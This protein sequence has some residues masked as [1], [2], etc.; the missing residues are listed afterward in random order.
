VWFNAQGNCT[1]MF[2]M[3]SLLMGQWQFA[4]VD[5]AARVI[6]NELDQKNSYYREF[7]ET[8][9][10]KA[11]VE[12][13]QL[14]LQKIQK[15]ISETKYTLSRL[16]QAIQTLKINQ[17]NLMVRAVEIVQKVAEKRGWIIIWETQEKVTW[18]ESEV[19]ETTV[20][21]ENCISHHLQALEI[22]FNYLT[23]QLIH[24]EA[25]A[26]R[27]QSA[28]ETRRVIATE[29]LNRT[30]QFITVIMVVA[31]FAQ[32]AGVLSDNS[33]LFPM[34]LQQLDHQIFYFLKPLLSSSIV[35]LGLFIVFITVFVFKMFGRNS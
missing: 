13:L 20:I 18:F 27:W 30:G 23:G 29:K 22:S 8:V 7:D 10:L 31:A 9:L 6:M 17:N 19:T 12:N 11:T 25:S 26:L 33:T 35:Y 21:L 16:T 1:L 5:A 14:E 28:L 32:I 2:L 24:L 4:H 34:W 15:V 3:P